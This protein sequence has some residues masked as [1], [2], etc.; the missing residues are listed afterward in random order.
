MARPKQPSYI[1]NQYK[2]NGNVTGVPV[3]V[4]HAA[5]YTRHQRLGHLSSL[6]YLQAATDDGSP[7]AP[8]GS[9]QPYGH[10]QGSPKT[11]SLVLMGLLNLMF[12][13][14]STFSIVLTCTVS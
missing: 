3:P 5:V 8:T 14:S 13:L 12:W 10:N 4:A 1:F 7:A 6:Q 11:T 9:C 2:Q